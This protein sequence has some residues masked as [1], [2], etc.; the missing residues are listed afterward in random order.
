MEKKNYFILNEPSIDRRRAYCN[1]MKNLGWLC[2]GINS[3]K[4]MSNYVTKYRCRSCEVWI[5]EN[6]VGL[7]LYEGYIKGYDYFDVVCPACNSIIWCKGAGKKSLSEYKMIHVPVF[8]SLLVIKKNTLN[9]E[10][11]TILKAYGIS[12][13]AAKRYIAEITFMKNKKS[14]LSYF[15]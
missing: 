10:V 14:N 6:K 2:F 11:K 7:R 13:N 5:P 15:P 8:D 4:K 9:H 12:L 3:D 1:A